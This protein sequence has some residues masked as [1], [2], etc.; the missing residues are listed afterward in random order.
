MSLAFTPNFIFVTFFIG[1]SINEKQVSKENN[2]NK[3][4]TICMFYF[5]TIL[6][7]INNFALN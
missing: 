4:T 5:F 1:L 2:T 7:D 6:N 3:Q